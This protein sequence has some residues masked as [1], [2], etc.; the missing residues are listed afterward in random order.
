MPIGAVAKMP[1][2]GA[3]C[4]STLEPDESRAQ[5]EVDV[6]L[7]GEERLVEEPDCLK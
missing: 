1:T 2:S 7:I 6:F 5:G 4:Q 3:K